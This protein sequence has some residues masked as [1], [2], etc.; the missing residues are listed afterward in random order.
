MTET[1]LPTYL[2]RGVFLSRDQLRTELGAELLSL[3][4]SVTADGRIAPEEIAGLR[5]WLS[6]AEA[7]DMLPAKYLRTVIDRVLADGKITS[8]EYKE[9]YRAVEAVLPVE[10]R[11]QAV[12]ARREAEAA[13]KAAARTERKAERRR[14]REERNSGAPV[15][16]VNFMVAAVRQEGRP[17]I[18]EQ[19]ATAGDRVVLERDPDSRDGNATIAVKL[20]NGT[21][22]G[23]VPE[24]DA[25][26]LAPLL[27]QG[28]R[29]EARI[30]TILTGG[31][32]PIPVVQVD[33]FASAGGGRSSET[34]TQPPG[35]RFGRVVRTAVIALVVLVILL[36]LVGL[37]T[38]D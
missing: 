29:Y 21:Q 4:Q 16:S 10:V 22:I 30:S 33:L 20:A 25:R 18:I 5:Q 7:A 2:N 12:V 19:Q 32:S 6:D 13:D 38:G 3:C 24:D 8:D 36:F 27:D 26:R 17:A 1:G 15:L 14:T 23:R 11:Q 34:V 31:R 28:C 9:V 37:P 35:E